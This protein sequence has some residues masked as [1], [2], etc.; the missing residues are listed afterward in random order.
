MLILLLALDYPYQLTH[1]T[2]HI[3]T[4]HLLQ[5]CYSANFA[6][7]RPYAR[8]ATLSLNSLMFK[9]TSATPRSFISKQR[10]KKSFISL[11]TIKLVPKIS[12]SSTYKQ[13]ITPSP[14][15]WR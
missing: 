11:I 9:I 6:H 10:D 3:Q 2:T 14:P 15:P 5:C 1:P 13:R 8:T 12:I 7:A 4:P